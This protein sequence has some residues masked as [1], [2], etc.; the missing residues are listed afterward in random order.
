[1][2]VTLFRAV[3]SQMSARFPL[4]LITGTSDPGSLR[5]R[6]E[7]LL[8]VI[9]FAGIYTQALSPVYVEGDDAMVVAY[10][11]LGRH[12]ELQPPYSSPTIR[13]SMRCSQFFPKMKG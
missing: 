10:H 7:V 4:R 6:T 13:C 8:V 9:V 12:A 3:Y 1:M 11:A 2:H 5:L